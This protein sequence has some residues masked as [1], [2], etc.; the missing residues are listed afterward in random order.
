MQH[1]ESA[2]AI[3]PKAPW[4]LRGLDERAV[5]KYFIFYL[6]YSLI[7]YGTVIAVMIY[8]WGLYPVSWWIV[9]LGYGAVPFTWPVMAAIKIRIERYLE[10]K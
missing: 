1:N 2:I 9:L 7:T 4:P 3:P 5:L 6:L 10:G 8:G